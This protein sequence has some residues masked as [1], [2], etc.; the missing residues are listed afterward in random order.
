MSQAKLFFRI[1]ADEKMLAG[2]LPLQYFRLVDI[3]KE[4][5]CEMQVCQWEYSAKGHEVI[6]NFVR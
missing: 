4:E 3:C 2:K 6:P 1:G 5:G